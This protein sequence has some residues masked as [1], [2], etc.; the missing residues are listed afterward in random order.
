MP[1]EA[2]VLTSPCAIT[3]VWSRRMLIDAL[4]AR[5]DRQG[6]ATAASIYVLERL[7]PTSERETVVTRIRSRPFSWTLIEGLTESQPA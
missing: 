6:G 7:I 4:K 3:D 5:S 1:I 2:S